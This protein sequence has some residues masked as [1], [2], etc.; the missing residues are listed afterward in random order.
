MLYTGLMGYK[1]KADQVAA[2]RRNYLANKDAIKARAKAFMIQ[3]RERNREYVTKIKAGPCTD[4]G[5][6]Y[7]PY[8]MQ[9]D[10]IGTD[11][12]FDVSTGVNDAYSISRLQQEIDK[13]E[14][15]CANCHAIRTNTRRFSST[16]KALV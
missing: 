1:N 12:S 11:K 4:C 15:V 9:F 3:A 16:G 10:H 2:S 8:V 7:P 5:Q 14:L 6:C 13:C